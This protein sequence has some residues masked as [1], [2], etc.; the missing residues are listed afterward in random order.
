[1][2]ALKEYHLNVLLVAKLERLYNISQFFFDTVRVQ[3]L[4]L[5]IP[6]KVHNN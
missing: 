4:T 1:M 3:L 6:V 2:G 5:D